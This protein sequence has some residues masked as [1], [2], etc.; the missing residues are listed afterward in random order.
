MKKFEIF[1]I[2]LVFLFTLT[3]A[4]EFNTGKVYLKLTNAGSTLF[5]A[6]D[7]QTLQI[8]RLSPLLSGEQYQV[9]DYLNDADSADTSAHSIS[10][11]LFGNFQVQSVFDNSYSF[12]PPAYK[13]ELNAFGWTNSDYTISHYNVTNIDSVTYQSKF[14]FE[15]LPFIDNDYGNEI[16]KYDSEDDYVRIYRDT[17]TTYVGLKILSANLTSLYTENWVSGYNRSDTALFNALTYEGI[18]DTF[19]AADSGSVLFPSIDP[20]ELNPG[21]SYD[22]YIALAAGFSEIELDSIMSEAVDRYVT[23]F[24]TDYNNEEVLPNKITLQ[25]NYPNPFNPSTV[26]QFNIPFR[27]RVELTIYNSIGQKVKTLLNLDLSAGLH[28]VEFNASNLASGVYFY[29]LKTDKFISTK[30]MMLLK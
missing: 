6:P 3:Q 8:T 20:V 13:I 17:V 19:T 12:D 11:P 23:T 1:L 4:Q 24:T 29:R 5:G 10:S 14:G 30:K 22:V 28:K 26:I 25:Q 27:Q 7:S 2:A 15:V 18:I 16:I 9:F 21:E